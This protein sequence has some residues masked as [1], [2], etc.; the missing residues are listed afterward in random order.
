MVTEGTLKQV[1][2][3]SKAEFVSLLFGD[4][5]GSALTIA[6]GCLKLGFTGTVIVLVPT[7]QCSLTCRFDTR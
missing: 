4:D 1:L 6:R 3:H 7:C 2:S 5:M